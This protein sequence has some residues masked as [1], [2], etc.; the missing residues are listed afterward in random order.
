VT[1]RRGA[2][3]IA[4]LAAAASIGH[5]IAGAAQQRPGAPAVQASRAP[6]VILL[7]VDTLRADHL[8]MYGY[9]R[10][11][12]PRLDAWARASTVFRQA[13]SQAACTFP[14]VN[15][16]LTGRYAQP[17]VGQPGQGMGIPPEIPTLA[18][19]LQ[20][21]G[22]TTAGVSASIVVRFHPSRVNRHGGFAA[23]FEAVDDSCLLGRASCVNRATLRLVDRVASSPSASGRPLFLYVHYLE[24]HA[25][26]APARRHRGTFSKPAPGLPLWLRRGD[27]NP[28]R[29]WLYRGGAPVAWG[30][31]EVDH[32]VDLY[33]EEILGADEGID[34]LLRELAARGRLENAVVAL[35]SDHGEEF[36]EHGHIYH[37]RTLFETSTRTPLI[38]QAPKGRRV[39]APVVEAPVENL[40]VMPTL[41]DYAGVDAPAGLEGRSLRPLIEGRAPNQVPRLWFA[42]QDA[43]RAVSDGRHKLILDLQDERHTLFDLELD[44]AEQSDV[45]ADRRREYHD[46]ARALED[47]IRRV[48]GPNSRRRSLERAE[49]SRKALEALGYL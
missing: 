16:L 46:L 30:G 20:R 3:A 38:I 8:G 28:V 32:A 24:P 31:A 41:L 6:D 10:P 26:Y 14:A 44:P 35:V 43:L 48:E 40:D 21:A 22:Y 36:W 18:E 47:H 42:Q 12:S 4:V 27:L 7:L 25:A 1:A 34:A 2:T 37:C 15:S 9:G 45:L 29:D 17:F 49:E 5:W 13:R 39:A 23:G 19:V 33:D 11:T